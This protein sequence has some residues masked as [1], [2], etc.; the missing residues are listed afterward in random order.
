MTEEKKNLS[1]AEILGT[2]NMPPPEK[3]EDVAT[4]VY[5]LYQY[6]LQNMLPFW[7]VSDRDRNY[8]KGNQCPVYQNGDLK[9]YENAVLPAVETMKP[10]IINSVTKVDVAP[11]RD[12]DVQGAMALNQRV[13]WGMQQSHFDIEMP[14]IVHDILVDGWTFI[15]GLRNCTAIKLDNRTLIFDVAREDLDHSYFIIEQFTMSKGDAIDTF[16]KKAE[17]LIPKEHDLENKRDDPNSAPSVTGISDT[18]SS[19]SVQVGDGTL[20]VGT[21]YG[22]TFRY[23]FNDWD[24]QFQ[25]AES[26][27][28]L[29]CWVRDKSGHYVSKTDPKSRKKYREWIQYYP[30]GRVIYIGIG[31]DGKDKAV[32]NDRIVLRDEPNPFERL[33]VKTGRFPFVNINCYKTSAHLGMSVITQL[34]SIQDLL[35]S[36]HKRLAKNVKRCVKPRMIWHARSGIKPIH[37]TDADNNDIHLSPSTDILPRDAVHVIDIPSIIQHMAP[38]IAMY[39]GIIKEVSGTND[40]MRGSTP[41]GVTSGIAINQL[42]TTASSRPLQKGDTIS[43]GMIQVAEMLA[44]IAQEFD[45]DG[46]EM[47][48][49]DDSGTETQFIKYRPGES[50]SLGFRV[51]GT[52][53]KSLEEIAQ[54]CVLIANLKQSGID[55]KV[56]LHYIDDPVF[57]KLYIEAEAAMQK[58]QAEAMAAQAKMADDQQKGEFAKEVALKAMENQSKPKPPA[59]KSNAK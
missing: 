43:K 25:G 8:Y 37:N 58:Q 49:P 39:R 3:Q 54:V 40:V 17:G 56:L 10:I 44:Y 20:P 50:K 41:T 27:L 45:E 51:V 24:N 35:N 4:A 28:V 33:F 15:T 29:G 14:N 23:D 16:G 5:N 38:L 1:A 21:N 42:Q 31:V 26:V 30:Q 18:T 9:C 59:G 19:V 36:A 13:K 55:P 12:K 11:L 47:E 7:R 22:Q 46:V 57:E 2:G 32:N 48:F 6:G 34:L 53:K 52:R